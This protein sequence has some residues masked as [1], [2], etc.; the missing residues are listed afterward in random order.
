M[1][2]L[3]EKLRRLLLELYGTPYS[4]NIYIYFFTF[5]GNDK[6]R[7]VN[8]TLNHMCRQSYDRSKKPFGLQITNHVVHFKFG[9]MKKQ[10]SPCN[11]VG[12]SL[13]QIVKCSQTS[14]SNYPRQSYLRPQTLDMFSNLAHIFVVL[15]LNV[16]GGGEEG[17]F[18]FFSWS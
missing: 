8:V 6:F 10:Q 15:L 14:N 7:I 11:V 16:F 5:W 13:V 17:V 18:Y 9:N 2:Q 3:I 4:C 1:I 12:A